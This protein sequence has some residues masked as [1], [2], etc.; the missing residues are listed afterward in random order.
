MTNVLHGA[1][2]TGLGPEGSD[3]SAARPIALREARGMDAGRR[4]ERALPAWR[5]L[6]DRGAEGA[7]RPRWARPALL[8]LLLVTAVAYIWGL[9]ANGWGNSFYSAAVQAGSADWTAFLFGSSDAAN[10]ITVDKPP[11]SLW[12]MALSVR[13]FGLNSWAIMVPQ[14]LMGVASVALLAHSVHL[15]VRDRLSPTASHAAGLLA[16]LLLASTPVAVLMFRFNNPDAL[17]VLVMIVAVVATQH[18]LRSGHLRWAALAGLMV[19]IGFLTKQLQVALILPGL[20]LAALLCTTMPWRRRFAQV[21]VAL[22]SAIVSAGWW[23]ALVEL[24]PATERPYVGGSQSNS[25]LELTFGYNGLGR[26][27]GDESG[28]V[29]G[30]GGWGETGITRLFTDAMGQQIAWW[31]PTALVLT[32]VALLL[33][34]RRADRTSAAAAASLMWG[35]W[36]VVTWLT[37]SFMS[38]IIHEYYTVALA[39]AIAASVAIGG[40][41]L[42]TKR[43]AWVLPVIGVLAAGTAAWMFVLLSADGWPEY[44]RWVVLA[45]GLLAG[46]LAVLAGVRRAMSGAGSRLMVAGLLLALGGAFAAPLASSVV[47]LSEGHSG[48]I[49]TAG[50]ASTGGPGGGGAPGGQGGGGAQNAGGTPPAGTPPTGGTAPTGGGTTGTNGGGGMGGLLEGSAPSTELTDLLEA[51]AGDYTWAAATIGANNASGY[52]LATEL[53]VMPI[54]GFNG[55]DDSPTLAQ[56]QALVDAGDIH[57]FIA[58][59]GMGGGESGSS[60]DI[61]SWVEANFEAT[62]VDGITMYDLSS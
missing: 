41:L 54:G 62:T 7:Q 13:L 55:T 34:R 9:D 52:Q 21:A 23:V 17:L 39:P 51:E 35:S 20:V 27:T 12:V 57:W 2:P 5:R 37:F 16:G 36:L 10:S 1:A 59:G 53:P 3:H 56:F 44:L 49:V 47:T 61:T 18:G 8:A 58:G 31:L 42:V 22:G 26:L 45:S 14:A 60:S 46:V 4:E 6:I 50:P 48:S 15:A 38:G 11:A 43:A 40:V 32:V 24:T 19:G 25:F 28:S 33:L 29:G 30:G